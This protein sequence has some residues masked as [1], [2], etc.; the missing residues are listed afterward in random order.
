MRRDDKVWFECRAV[1]ESVKTAT[2]R[3]MMKITPFE[4]DDSVAVRLFVETLKQIRESR[5]ASVQ[6]H[7]A[8]NLNSGTQPINGLMINTRHMDAGQRRNLY[9]KS[10]LNDQV[11]WYLRKARRNLNRESFWFWTI[12]VIQIF[13]ITFAVVQVAFDGLPVNMIPLLMTCAASAVAWG[14]IKRYGEL[15]QTYSLAAQE[16][17]EQETLAT[18]AMKEE[19]FLELVESIEET[20]SREHTLWR[21]RR[22]Y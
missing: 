14:Q 15:A 17:K 1:A 9:L 12:G 7:L 3:F 13:A 19:D 4:G 16:L 6:K 22:V 11:A 5:P 8:K 18:Y 10:R 21:V 2:W 20:I